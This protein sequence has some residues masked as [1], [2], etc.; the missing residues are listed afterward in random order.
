MKSDNILQ[1]MTVLGGPEER[2]KT[3]SYDEARGELRET[4]VKAVF[5]AEWHRTRRRNG[6]MDPGEFN[7]KH[8]FCFLHDRISFY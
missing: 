2:L 1:E 8:S 3:L 6:R 4:V 7:P 5:S